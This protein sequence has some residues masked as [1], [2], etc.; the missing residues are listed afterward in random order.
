[1]NKF[2]R[3]IFSATALAGLMSGLIFNIGA[4]ETA[5]QPQSVEQA[6]ITFDLLGLPDTI[7]NGPYATM[8]VVFGTPANWAFQTGTE[9][10]LILTSQLATDSSLTVADGQYIGATM[11]V[12]L[13]KRAIAILP[14]IAGKDVSYNIPISTDVLVSPYSDG[15]HEL[16]LFL[17]SGVDCRY[18]FHRTSVI[19]SAASQFVLPHD[20]Q[21]PLTDLTILPRP[22]YQRSSVFPINADVV[23]PDAPSAQELQAALIAVASFGRM[24]SGNLPVALI[25]FSQLTPELQ[26]SSNLILVGKASA[27]SSLLQVVNLPAPVKNNAFNPQGMLADDGILELAVSPWN[28][29]RSVLI[30][31]GNTDVGVVKAVQALSNN[32]IQTGKVNSL[33]VI[34]DVS[35][36]DL[37][38]NQQSPAFPPKDTFTFSDLGYSNVSLSGPGVIDS[39]VQFSIPI[40]MV[41]NGDTY[42]D[43]TFNNSAQLDFNSSGLS[44]YV[45]GHLIG[46]AVL[47]QKTTSTVTQRIKIPLSVLTPGSNQLKLEADLVPLT[48]C[49]SLNISNL[50]ISIL[51]ESILHLPLT[52]APVSITPTQDLS[53]Y[54]YPFANEPTLSNLA[55]AVAKNDPAAWNDTAQ[56]AYWLGRRAS[57]AIIDFALAYDG[58][59]SDKVLQSHDMIVV[60]LPKNLKLITDLSKSLPAPFD[61]GSNVAILKGQQ[62]TY[63]FPADTDLGY[64]ELMPSPWNSSYTILSVVGSTPGGV[65]LSRTALTDTAQSSQLKG[66]LAII[67]NN[68]ITVADTRTGLG[69]SAINSNPN[70][71]PQV[72]PPQ[73]IPT[74]VPSSTLV[75]SRYWIPV[76]IVV[77]VF[78]IIIVLIVAVILSRRGK[79]NQEKRPV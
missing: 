13:D 10:Q 4:A 60:G 22:I 11:T 41:A 21:A 14:L 79:S 69:L 65:Q 9:L 49:S 8:R 50:S 70:A 56:I 33:A 27:L 3:F 15:H 74:P 62:V 73:G 18:N 64:L 53:T 31:S 51:S 63:R 39:F 68:T 2:L 77:L 29:A 36:V 30:V 66:N 45:N 32:N 1:M 42:L 71:T 75:S 6:T 24:S 12:T 76:A 58:E 23:I 67:A 28:G 55:F 16:S 54:P 61:P 57:G 59:I 34:G 47:S 35:P 5:R 20:E 48:Q 40:G 44:V 19:V 43:L 17:D 7:M 52:Q 26:A 72:T 46:A 78:L 37:S 38:A 25:P